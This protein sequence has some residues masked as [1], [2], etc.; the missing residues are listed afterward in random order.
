MGRGVS[1]FAFGRFEVFAAGV[2]RAAAFSPRARRSLAHLVLPGEAVDRARLA[3]DLWP[4]ESDAKGLGN[5]RRR[6]H[7][8]DAALRAVG[9]PAAIER[10]RDRVSLAPEALW[11]VDVSHYL[12]LCKDLSQADRAAA[13]Y[14][15]P[16]FPGVDDAVVE[17]ERRRLRAI[18][19]DLLS[20]LLER[21]IRMADAGGVARHARALVEVDPLS[22]RALRDAVAALERF[23]DADGA[24]RLYDAF[25]AALREEADVEAGPFERSRVPEAA[26]GEG[27]EREMR[28][29]L[30]PVAARGAE[31]R[32]AGA[33]GAFDGVEAQFDRIAAALEMAIVRGSD[34]ELGAR[35]LAALSRFFFDRG[36]ARRACRWYDEA[37]AR[38]P[39]P[40]PLRAEMLYLRAVVGRNLGGAE[41]NLPA[42]ERAVGELRA[43]GDRPTLGKALLYAANAARMTGRVGLAAEMANEALPIFA[44]AGDTYMTAFARSAIGAAAYARGDVAEAREEFARA[45]KAFAQLGAGDD[46]ALMAADVGRCE[47]ALGRSERAREL[48]ERTAAAAAAT[49]NG[50]V[51]GH[52]EVG[53][54]LLAVERSD[55]SAARTHASRAAEI[56]VA[57]G[58]TELAVIALEAA[59]ELF[60]AMGERARSRDALA[61]ADGVRSEY[62]IARAPTEHA[63]S[64][65]LRSELAR[66]RMLVE[67]PVA[68]PEVMMRAL[69][70]SVAR[71]YRR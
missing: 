18:Q 41:H 8:L 23:G 71:S 54:A 7:E 63:R 16:V 5:L 11:S 40:S 60:Y 15:E 2:Q 25:A 34:L 55:L 68:L 27:A 42:F 69:L 46:E 66:E 10:T 13:L 30:E 47:F 37:I 59:A 38:M 44:Q 48:L 28:A 57:N 67:S 26:L 14:R 24:R 70:E 53:L 49:N 32:G 56:A 45:R 9:L 29:V 51:E 17:R 43:C 35:A 6:L 12:L 21:A 61:A 36:H 4:E 22:E 58:D 3:A 64:E 19:V 39:E 62:L 31:L 52:A 20:F 33:A 50:Y 65:R 1:I